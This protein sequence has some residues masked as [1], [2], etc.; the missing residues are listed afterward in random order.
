[1]VKPLLNDKDKGPE[2]AGFLFPLVF[3]GFAPVSHL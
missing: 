2:T 3:K 1:M